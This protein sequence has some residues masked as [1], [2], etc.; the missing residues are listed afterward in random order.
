MFSSGFPAVEFQQNML[1]V[2]E[3]MMGLEEKGWNKT[4]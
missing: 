2:M 1:I 4:F 3:L